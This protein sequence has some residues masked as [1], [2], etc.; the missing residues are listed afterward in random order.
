MGIKTKVNTS[1]SGRAVLYT[2]GQFAINFLSVISA[3][4]FVRLMTTSE[5]GMAAVYFTWV[6][7]LSNSVGLRADSSI[8]NG[9]SEFGE[10]SLK[11]YVSSICALS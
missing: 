6:S 1:L 7:I 10:K 11:S 5:Y 2:V 4:I 3:P 9:W 8:Q